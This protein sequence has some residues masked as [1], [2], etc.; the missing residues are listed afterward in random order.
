VRHGQTKGTARQC[1]IRLATV[2][3]K[4]R[5]LIGVLVEML[6]R[7]V[8]VLAGHHAAQPVENS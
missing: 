1:A 4:P 6:R 5:R 8:A 7:N 3:V 2:I